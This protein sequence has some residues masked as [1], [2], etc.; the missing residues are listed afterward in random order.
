[1]RAGSVGARTPGKPC[2]PSPRSASLVSAAARAA[3]EKDSLGGD[4]AGLAELR[5]ERHR[6]DLRPHSR[7]LLAEDGSDGPID[8]RVGLDRKR[9]RAA[10]AAELQSGRAD[11]EARTPHLDATPL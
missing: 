6:H 1:P 2:P 9:D 10:D 8:Q 4:R 7:A 11:A 5:V 3:A